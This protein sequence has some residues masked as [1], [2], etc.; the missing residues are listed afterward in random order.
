MTNLAGRL[1]HRVDIEAPVITRGGGGSQDVS[2][3]LFARIWAA[4]EPLS[5]KE[6][7]A[8][9]QTQSAIVAR[10]IIRYRSDLLPEMRIKHNGT[11]YNPAGFL[12]DKDSGLEYLTIP[13]TAGLNDGS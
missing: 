12:P 4:I 6:M 7:V 13:L 2:W 11:I 9:A 3:V 1:R 10:M 8:A 5:V